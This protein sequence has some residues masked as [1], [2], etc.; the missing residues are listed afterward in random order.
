MRW[1]KLWQSDN[2]G[3]FSIRSD[4]FARGAV[5]PNILKSAARW[6][7]HWIPLRIPQL[8]VFTTTRTRTLTFGMFC[9]WNDVIHYKSAYLSLHHFAHVS[10]LMYFLLSPFKKILPLTLSLSPSTYL[11]PPCSISLSPSP[12]LYLSLSFFLSRTISLSLPI[13]LSVSLSHL[14]SLSL[15]RSLYTS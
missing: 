6:E 10:L 4:S 1:F 11:S 5:S 2:C 7:L 12:S 8:S 14:L 15:S 3:S 9:I 13:S